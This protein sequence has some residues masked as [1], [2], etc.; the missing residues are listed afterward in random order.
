L[1]TGVLLGKGSQIGEARNCH[2]GSRAPT[3]K[4]E[5]VKFGLLA[6]RSATA[7]SHFY[8]NFIQRRLSFTKH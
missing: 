5:M 6:Q 4:E 7:H 1:L 2:T 3:K 8:M